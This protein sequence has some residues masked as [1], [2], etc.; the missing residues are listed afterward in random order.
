MKYTWDL[1]KLRYRRKILEE[2]ARQTDN[3][4]IKANAAEQ[5][6]IYTEMLRTSKKKSTS[7]DSLD[8]TYQDLNLN[9][10]IDEII[11]SYTPHNLPFINVLL[12][13]FFALSDYDTSMP[14]TDNICVTTN[15]E[16]VNITRDFFK[17]KTPKYIAKEFDNIL[18]QGDIININYSKSDSVYPGYTLYDYFLNKKYIFIGR[19]NH[20]YDLC[21]LPHEAFHYIFRDR[22]VGLVGMFDTYY[23]TEVEGMFANILFG[24]YFKEN[25]SPN[26]E[27]FNDYSIGLFRNNINDLVTR[28]TI[29]D[30]LKKNKKIRLSKLNKYLG[31]F[32]VLPFKNEEELLPYLTMPEEDIIKYALSYLVALDLYYMYKKDPEEAFYALSCITY[33]K[34]TNNIFNL[35]KNNGITFMNDDYANLKKYIKNRN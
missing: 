19:S 26:N 4:D 25:T 3:Y 21:I 8:D 24:E 6:E 32:E 23:L 16:L 20:L 14:E 5:A 1:E 18:A 9:E 10:L 11:K 28:N 22:N 35:L 13:S 34:Q 27:Y 2:I 33:I 31:Y 12:Q 30:S 7:M 29:L 15:Q 17:K